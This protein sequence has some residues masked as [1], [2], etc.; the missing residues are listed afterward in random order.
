LLGQAQ[1][2][3]LPFVQR[4]KTHGHQNHVLIGRHVVKGGPL[5]SFQRQAVNRQLGTYMGDVVF[6]MPSLPS[7]GENGVW[8]HLQD[9]VD[10]SIPNI[11]E[12]WHR[13]AK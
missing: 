4:V 3:A 11:S 5:T 9:S 1:F 13:F 2:D 6:W 10:D 7:Q 12:I 8:A